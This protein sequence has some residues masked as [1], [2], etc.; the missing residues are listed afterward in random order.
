MCSGMLHTDFLH[1]AYLKLVYKH[2][3][4]YVDVRKGKIKIKGMKECTLWIECIL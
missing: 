1:N 3:V 4:L 2:T